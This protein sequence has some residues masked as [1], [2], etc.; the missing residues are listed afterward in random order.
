MRPVLRYHGGKWKLAEWIL[1]YFP[2]HRIYVE[3]YG[4]GGSV[5]MQKPRS[6]AEVYNDLWDVVVNVFA[7]M[8]DPEKAAKL[9]TALELTPFSR[10]EFNGAS[11]LKPS[12]PG[13]VEVAR[14]TIL[15]SFSGFG[16]AATNG[17]YSTGF[18]CNS[19][20]SGTTP[21]HDWVNYPS[22]IEAYVKRL[23]GVVI[24]NKNA[25]DV[26][27]QHDTPDTLFYVDPP[28]PLSTRNVAR[29]NA[30]YACDMTDDDHRE[31]AKCLRSVAG[32][33]IL[34]GYHC[35][36]YDQELYADWVSAE[37][38]HL[39]DGARE[40]T[41]VLWMNKQLDKQESFAFSEVEP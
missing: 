7:V 17:E 32:T 38:L 3:P 39:A 19:N 4:G 9:R 6:Y 41:E 37:R 40:R 5:L 13:D 23:K 1:S 16:S 31:L 27:T 21:A 36:L 18:R 14:L 29:G 20:R 8:R 15:R 10:T 25:L 2:D 35:D 34:S 30:A 12:C 24:E 28:Y 22:H 26:I 11:S 33:V